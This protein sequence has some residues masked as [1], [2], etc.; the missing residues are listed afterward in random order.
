MNRKNWLEQIESYQGVDFIKREIYYFTDPAIIGTSNNVTKTDSVLT[1]ICKKGSA[2]CE[3]GLFSISLKATSMLV[4]LPGQLFKWNGFSPDFDGVFIIMTRRFYEDLN[5]SEGFTAYMSIRDNVCFPLTTEAMNAISTY[6]EMLLGVLKHPDAQLNKR[7]ITKHLTIAYFYG[8]G[9][10][11]HKW[12]ADTRK[13][14][15]EVIM[16]EFLQQ[17]RKHCYREHSVSFYAD[18]LCI[19]PKYLST[20]VKKATG[21]TASEWINQYIILEAKNLISS[22]DM[23]IQQISEALNFPSQSF[24]G[25]F[26]KREVGVTPGKYRGR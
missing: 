11:I 6:C 8:L 16:E 19:T 18:R 10:Y 1:C 3:I 4:I 21:K 2:T 17:V 14:R 24:F 12:S 15:E 26:F 22:T 13:V 20:A 5:V 9:Y 7:M 23:T 25:K